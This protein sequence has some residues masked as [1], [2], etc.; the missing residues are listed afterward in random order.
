MTRAS[1]A[2]GGC[3]IAST[4]SLRWISFCNCADFSAE[5][6]VI[7]GL[8]FFFEGRADF[9][10]VRDFFERADLSK[11]LCDRVRLECCARGAHEF[12]LDLGA[13]QRMLRAAAPL[14]D[15]LLERA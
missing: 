6:A 15:V 9:A 2:V 3:S 13:R 14:L 10:Q 7:I 11:Q 8:G 4:L 5:G 12:L 1:A